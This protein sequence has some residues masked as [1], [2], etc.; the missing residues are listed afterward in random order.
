MYILN[1]C[2]MP[3]D[4]GELLCV[5][6]LCFWVPS[7]E[8]RPSKATKAGTT[9]PPFL[10][11]ELGMRSSHALPFHKWMHPCHA[12]HSLNEFEPCS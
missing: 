7:D 12:M 9:I 10:L 8:V 4:S 5:D 1:Q 2:H 6:G 3:V 11:Q